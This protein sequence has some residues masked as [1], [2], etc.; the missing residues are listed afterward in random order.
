MD[1]P[2]SVSVERDMVHT[3]VVKNWSVCPF[4]ASHEPVHMRSGV[5]RCAKSGGALSAE[6]PGFQAEN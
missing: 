5:G 6:V 2:L 1:P 4:D 3:V